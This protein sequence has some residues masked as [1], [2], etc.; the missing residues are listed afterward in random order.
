MLS[1]C[2]AAALTIGMHIG[3]YHT[4]DNSRYNNS[5][6]GLYIAY[7]GYTAGTYKNSYNKQT[8]YAG[9]AFDI[10]ENCRYDVL[11][12]AATGYNIKGSSVVPF[13]VGSAKFNIQ[14]EAILRVSAIPQVSSEGKLKGA[15]LH[16]SLQRNF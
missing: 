3:S 2:S 9:K 16:L 8:V 12:G 11:V 4:A 7:D 6:P 13:V 5:N 10:A 15:V 14:D 1:L